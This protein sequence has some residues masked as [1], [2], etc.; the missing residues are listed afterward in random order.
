MAA[1]KKAAGTPKA[2]QTRLP[3]VEVSTVP[4][5]EKAAHRYVEAR[6]ELSSAKE[7]LQDATKNLIETMH[8]AKMTNYRSGEYLIE[9]SELESIK[10][11]ELDKGQ[12]E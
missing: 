12:A 3:G 9:I 2:K 6:S 11:K 8:K 5:V 10:V 7:V 4:A 1:K